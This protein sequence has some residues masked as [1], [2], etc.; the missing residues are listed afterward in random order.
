MTTANL[1]LHLK[2]FN[3]K[4]KVMN[5][6]GKQNLTL[7]VQEA[8]SLHADIFDLLN[9][10]AQLSKQTASIAKEQ[11]SVIQIAVDGGGFK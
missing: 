1:S 7:S 10:C 4:V 2:N 9:H 6:S 8:R 11:N 5:Q 3:E